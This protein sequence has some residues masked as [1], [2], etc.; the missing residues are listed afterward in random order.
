MA[1]INKTICKIADTFLQRLTISCIVVLVAIYRKQGKGCSSLDRS[2]QP[3]AL[4]SLTVPSN[5]D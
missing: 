4:M 3:V 1:W 5:S 2:P